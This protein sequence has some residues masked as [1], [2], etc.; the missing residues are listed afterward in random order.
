MSDLKDAR[1][2]IVGGSSGIGLATAQAALAQGGIVTIASRSADRLAKAAASLGGRVETLQL[3]VSSDD[4]VTAA[5]Q[6]AGSWDHV[7]ITAGGGSSTRPPHANGV[8]DVPLNEAGVTFD[9]KFWGAYRVAA[10]ADIRS[11]GSITFVSGIYGI[12]P[13]RGRAMAAV[14]GAALEQLARVLALEIAP[15]RVNVIAPGMVD[16]PMWDRLPPGAK[17]KL[18]AQ[19]ASSVPIGRPGRADEIA[20]M[21]VQCMT[22]GMLTG[23]TLICDGGLT[24]T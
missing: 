7:A 21:I 5:M 2:L 16:T 15:S 4:A 10:K 19:A 17:D 13:E 24:L 22:N 9:I 11:G 8:R 6:A 23:A 14:S 1:I 20:A 3:D 12:R 18:F